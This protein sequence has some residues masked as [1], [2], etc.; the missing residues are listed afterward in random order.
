MFAENN[1]FD[2][3]SKR[4]GTSGASSIHKSDEASSSKQTQLQPSPRINLVQEMKKI[5]EK[6][7]DSRFNHSSTTTQKSTDN[8]SRRLQEDE[9]EVVSPVPRRTTARLRGIKK[10]KK[11]LN[12]EN[13]FHMGNNGEKHLKDIDKRDGERLRRKDKHKVT[14]FGV[15][16]S[17]VLEAEVPAKSR[18]KQLK[19]IQKS[20][21]QQKGDSDDNPMLRKIRKVVDDEEERL[22]EQNEEGDAEEPEK[23][24]NRKGKSNVT[25]A[26]EL[27]A[28]NA[29]ESSYPCGEIEQPTEE[30]EEHAVDGEMEQSGGEME[31]HAVDGEMEQSG[32][33]MEEHAAGGEMEQSGGEMEQPVGEIEEHAADGEI[34]QLGGEIEQSIGEIEEHTADR[35]MKQSG[36]ETESVGETE[37]HATDGEMEQS[38]GEI[39]QPTGEI[40]QPT[41]EIK[42]L[43][44]EIESHEADVDMVKADANVV[45][46]ELEAEPKLILREVIIKQE[47]DYDSGENQNT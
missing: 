4:S 9:F 6:N 13:E 12:M 39:E 32:G 25:E 8:Q 46:K 40:K 18:H 44:E 29:V 15:Q 5:K 21:K 31:E 35:E 27:Q 43:A 45:M 34:E 37:E 33:E 41:G 26:C 20:R 42:Q 19:R 17:S 36:G 23:A 2:V 38:G 22:G 24:Q 28:E 3:G 47:P 14:G 11:L 1:A 16:S 30:I 10:L 7:C